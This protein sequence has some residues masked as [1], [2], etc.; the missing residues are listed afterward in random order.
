MSK[1][2]SEAPC[3]CGGGTLAD[4]CGPFI[5]GDRLAPTAETLMRSRYSAYARGET[6]YLLRT[7]H[8]SSRPDDFELQDV[9]QWR[10]LNI[11]ATE[12]GGADDTTGQVEFIA[13]YQVAGRFDQLHERSDFRR[14]DGAW[15]YVDGVEV[16]G[17]PVTVVKVGRNE[18]CPCGSGKKYKRCCQGK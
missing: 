13:S 15:Y 9:I 11:L 7:W 14:E 10:G 5:A 18:P 16:K 17:R 4:C 3:P 2:E 6:D 1:T 8:P 12:A